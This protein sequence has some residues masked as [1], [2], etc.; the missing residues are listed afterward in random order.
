MANLTYQP[1]KHMGRITKWGMGKTKNGNPQL[2]FSAE[3][4]GKLNADGSLASCPQ[5]ERTVFRV[6]TDKT[7]EYIVEDLKNLGYPHETF[8]QLD[9]SAPNAHSFAGL[10]VPLT[11]KHDTYEGKTN[12][13]WEFAFGGA[14]YQA[15][16]L[17]RRQV[18]ELNATFG[19]FLR[20]GKTTPPASIPMAQVRQ[21]QDAQ[22]RQTVAEAE[23]RF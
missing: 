11:C 15:V 8:D 1:G 7:I 4:I 23:E 21:Q 20:G 6:I 19:K 12:E 22:Y 18:A 5:F 2:F 9:P 3:I 16:P 14:G 13:K 17:E 10:Q